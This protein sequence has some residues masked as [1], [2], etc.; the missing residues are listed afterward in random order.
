MIRNRVEEYQQS[1]IPE[2]WVNIDRSQNRLSVFLHTYPFEEKFEGIREKFERCRYEERKK[3]GILEKIQGDQE[4]RHFDFY[5]DDG[6]KNKLTVKE[7]RSAAGRKAFDFY[8]LLKLFFACMLK[9]IVQVTEVDQELHDNPVLQLECFGGGQ[10]PSYDVLAAFDRDMNRHGLMKQVRKI[11][12]ASNFAEGIN[13]FDGRLIVDVTHSEGNGKIG[14]MTKKC[15]DCHRDKANSTCELCVNGKPCDTPK[16]TDETIDIVHKN[17]G[18]VMKAH[19]Y[20]MVSTGIEL[21]LGTLAF[22]GKQSDGGESFEQ[23]LREI[24][25]DNGPWIDKWITQFKKPIVIYADGIYN[26]AA[27]REM[28]VKV[29]GPGTKLSSKPNPGNRKTHKI[30]RKGIEFTVDKRA[31][32]RCEKGAQFKFDAREIDKDRYRFVID[33]KYSCLSCPLYQPCSGKAKEGKTLRIGKNLLPHYDWDDPEFTK[34]YEKKYTI[35]TGIERIIGRGKDLLGFRRQFK[36]GR[37][38]V[39]GFGDR[40]TAMMNMI[41]YVAHAIGHPERMLQCKNFATG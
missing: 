22:N 15:R 6:V 27:N 28:V 13:E 41:A 7:R 21:L 34:S 9:N 5:D 2:G 24:K 12:V 11:A 8:G 38:N 37:S 20:Q 40:L 1:F 35:R 25:T 29:F 19:K 17:K 36:R 23:I 16:L 39:Q 10:L 18:K 4:E 26:T 33:E 30:K 32:V 3:A 31:N 14:K